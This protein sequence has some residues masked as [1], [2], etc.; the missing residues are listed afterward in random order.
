MLSASN[1]PPVVELVGITKTYPGVIANDNIDLSLWRGEVHSLLGENGAGKSTLIGILSGM[2][3]PDAGE[4]RHNGLAVQISSPRHA[5]ERGIG[6]VYQH[7]LLVPTLTVLENLLL[8]VNQ[9]WRLG[10][11][12]A[13]RRLQE[14]SILLDVEI[15]PEAIV[16]DLALGQRQQVEIVRALWRGEGVLILDEPT[17]MLTPQGTQKL[18]EVVRRLADKGLAVVFITH[19]LNE[20]IDLGDR[21]SVLRRG[22]VVGE[23]TPDQIKN[24]GREELTENVL[25]M[26]FGDNSDETYVVRERV[27]AVA[28]DQTRFSVENIS[29]QGVGLRPTLDDVSFRLGKGEILGIAGIDGNG[30]KELAEILAGQR[31]TESGQILLDGEP[32][33]HLSIAARQ[34]KGIRYVTD[35][36][37]GEGTVG[38]LSVAMNVVLKRVGERPFW[39][40]SFI[41]LGVIREFARELIKQ[42]DVRTPSEDVGVSTLSGGNMQKLILARE[43]ALNPTVVVYNKPTY[44]LDARTTSLVL[45]GIALRAQQ[46]VS[47]VFISTE[48]SEIVAICHHVSVMYHGRLSES[49]DVRPG[50]EMQ[51][52]ALMTGSAKT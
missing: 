25:G 20:A 52:G 37:H 35:D 41:R 24:T 51:L 49:I 13:Q 16:G 12:G 31:R 7:S 33:Q 6:T 45:S 18:V 22:R 10:R 42:N 30:Q 5:L 19:K 48:L 38:P 47:T 34:A 11:E 28:G 44:G 1:P 39:R 27:M 26:I 4:I 8:G 17:S 43:L 2:V 21:V 50:I 9:G 32:I 3:Q 29:I 14:L 15:D 36:R 40:R 23:I 46:G